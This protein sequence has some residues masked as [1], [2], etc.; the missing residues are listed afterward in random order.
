VEGSVKERL[1]GALI[2]VALLVIVVPE[3]LSGPEE[4]PPA[5][6]A[7]AAQA[8]PPLRTYS[9]QLESASTG[10]SQDQS[11]LSPKPMVAAPEAAPAD[12]RQEESTPP[13]APEAAAP[14]K[15]A[16][17]KPAPAKPAPS[18]SAAR[19]QS[20]G[21]WWA[22]LGSFASRDNAERLSRE[23]RAA[24]YSVNLARVHAAGKELY[25]VRAGPEPSREAATS[26]QARLAAAGHKSSLVAP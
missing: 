12:A 5:R 7:Q 1:T 19:A 8:G 16:A 9:L 20:T 15:P 4:E 22:Q 2:L 3:M 23:L 24:G 21:Q 11:A 14:Q 10:R 25:R 6:P 17:A 13:A 18:V 26:L